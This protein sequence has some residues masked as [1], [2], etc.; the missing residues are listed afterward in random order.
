VRASS[1][2][3]TLA[4]RSNPGST[5]SSGAYHGPI[6]APRYDHPGAA[7]RQRYEMT[8]RSMTAAAN[9][10]AKYQREKKNIWRATRLLG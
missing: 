6:Q 4:A 8:M 1:L 2:N 9:N 10:N 5:L 3:R 7:V